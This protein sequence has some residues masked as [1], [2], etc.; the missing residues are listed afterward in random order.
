M[1]CPHC[2]RLIYSRQH[3][4]CGF[5]GHELPEELLLSDQE[6]AKLKTEQA[7]IAARRELA[8]AKEEEEREQARRKSAGSYPQPPLG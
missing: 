6:V 7:A 3:K 8:K 1:K 4:Q 2:D 5:C